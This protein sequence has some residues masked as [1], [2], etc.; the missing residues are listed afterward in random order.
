[1]ACA[2]YLRKLRGRPT[3][4]SDD[5]PFA[6]VPIHSVRCGPYHSWSQSTSA[7][8]KAESMSERYIWI[9]RWDEFQ[10]YK[11]RQPPWIK[12]YTRL[13]HDDDYLNLS[14]HRR[15]ILHG[16]WLVFASSSRRVRL[17][18]RSLS[19]RLQIRIT[20][21]DLKALNRAGFVEVVASRT[22]A[23]RLQDARPETETETE[24]ETKAVQTDSRDVAVTALDSIN[25]T[26][27]RT[28]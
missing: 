2:V 28:A 6:S 4:C 18:S 16:L 9:P 14:G 12:V 10:H 13:L 23:E 17:D 24:T 15:S 8:R 19:A 3:A 21:E 1:V 5:S 11:D 22:L 20:S 26:L 25:K 7:K 27:R